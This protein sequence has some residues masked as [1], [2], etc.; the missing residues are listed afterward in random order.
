MRSRYWSNCGKYLTILERIGATAHLWLR[1]YYEGLSFWTWVIIVGHH[2]T[3]SELPREGWTWSTYQLT[4]KP[5]SGTRKRRLSQFSDKSLKRFTVEP[6]EAVIGH[7]P[8]HP[9]KHQ[10]LFHFEPISG[11][12]WGI[13]LWVYTLPGVVGY[14]IDGQKSV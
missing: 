6:F 7:V 4:K 5:Y 10:F 3:S 2:L 12:K 14:T 11:Q 8:K 13:R 9:W 1:V